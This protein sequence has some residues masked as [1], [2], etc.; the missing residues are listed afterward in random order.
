VVDTGDG[1]D[2]NTPSCRRAEDVVD[3]RDGCDG[4]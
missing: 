1:C 3:I 4:C 2:W